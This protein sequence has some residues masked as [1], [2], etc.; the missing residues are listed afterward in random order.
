M[1]LDSLENN[2]LA[3]YDPYPTSLANARDEM[4]LSNYD[5]DSDGRCDHAACR[6]IPLLSPFGIFPEMQE[7]AESVRRD[8]E[9]IG[10]ELRIETTN[11]HEAYSLYDPR[12]KVPLA[13]FPAWSKDFLNASSWVPQLFSSEGIGNGNSSLVGATPAELQEW[14]YDVTSVPSIDDEIDRCLALVGDLQVRCWAEVDQTLM[15]T[16][17][18]WVPY[19]FENKVLL[20]SDTVDA[21]TFDQF[22]AEPA[23]DRIALSP[24]AA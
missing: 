8:L 2:Y 11:F 15:E 4:A 23:L 5:H 16:V 1:V 21:Y 6:G 19:V 14:G 10:I 17:V 7:L 13:I 3:T 9:G 22:A 18:P 24:D 20:V 12:A